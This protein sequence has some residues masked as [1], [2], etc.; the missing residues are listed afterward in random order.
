MDLNLKK[1]ENERQSV[2]K[3]EYGSRVLMI[4]LE[5][6]DDLILQLRDF[7]LHQALSIF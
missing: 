1:R 3:P 7:D 4:S 5:V 2:L 6:L